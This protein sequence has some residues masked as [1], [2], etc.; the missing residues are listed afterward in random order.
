MKRP[1]KSITRRKA[2]RPRLKPTLSTGRKESRPGALKDPGVH[3]WRKR[4]QMTPRPSA[5][6]PVLSKAA[7]VYAKTIEG[8]R[9]LAIEFL[10]KAGII[11]KPGKLSRPYRP[12]KPSSR[13]APDVRQ[14]PSRRR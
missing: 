12:L 4:S 10:R 9:R 13:T 14:K 7:L 2:L 6:S 3:I 11:E 1:R 5:D 8:N